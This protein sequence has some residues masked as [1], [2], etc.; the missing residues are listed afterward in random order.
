LLGERKDEAAIVLPK[1]RKHHKGYLHI[2]TEKA[3]ITKRVNFHAFRH[4]VAIMLLN[5]GESLYTVSKILG[6]KSTKTTEIYGMLLTATKRK[7][8]NK[9]TLKG[10]KK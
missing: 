2:W 9:L 6:H 1:L 10:K 5:D 4:S 3:G 8:V 7:A